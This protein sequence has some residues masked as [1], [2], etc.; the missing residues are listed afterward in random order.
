MDD[1]LSEISRAVCEIRDLVRLLA[2]PAIATRDQKL[3]DELRR[4]VGKSAT[5]AESVLLMDGTRTQRMIQ[6][7]TEINKGNLSTLVKTLKAGKLLSGD[8]KQ[9]RLAIAIPTNF[10][11]TENVDD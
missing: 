9:P 11:E 1:H 8:G 3:R 2:E 10:F 7:E 5:K 4:I 6:L